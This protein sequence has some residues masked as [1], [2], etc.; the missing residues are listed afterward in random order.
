MKTRVA[1]EI[2]CKFANR[3]SEYLDKLRTLPMASENIQQ[4]FASHSRH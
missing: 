1:E 4:L 2:D 3:K